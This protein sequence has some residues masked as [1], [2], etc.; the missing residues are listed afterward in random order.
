MVAVKTV[1]ARCPHCGAE[2]LKDDCAC[3]KCKHMLWRPGKRELCRCGHQ[4]EYHVMRGEHDVSPCIQ[5]RCS[6]TKFEA[7]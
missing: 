5:P 7:T 1:G 4:R 3:P 6:C 2:V